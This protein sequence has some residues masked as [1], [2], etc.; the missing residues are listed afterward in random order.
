MLTEQ[1]SH[2]ACVLLLSILA[3]LHPW[4]AVG[5]SFGCCFYMAYPPKKTT[6]LARAALAVFSWGFGFA[7]AVFFF[8]EGPPYSPAAMFP[9]VALSAL[10]VVLGLAVVKMVE[11]NGPLPL[12]VEGILD[13]IPVLKRKGGDNDL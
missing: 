1:C 7:G 11:V 12:W 5:A 9:A 4:A 13:R 8:P 6:Y 10:G 2:W 3:T